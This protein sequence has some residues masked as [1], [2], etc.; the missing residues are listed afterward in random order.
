MAFDVAS[1][2]RLLE[3]KLAALSEKTALP[4]AMLELVAQTARL[5]L[6]A[7]ATDDVVVDPDSLED[8]ERVLRGAPMMP[9]EAFPVDFVLARELFEKLGEVVRHSEPHLAQALGIIDKARASDTLEL[10]QAF[11]RYVAGDDVF[12]TTFGRQTPQAP[13]LLNFLIQAALAPRLAAV[14][15]AVHAHFPADRT[16]NLGQCPVCASPPLIARLVG[17]EGA[18]YLTCSFCLLEYRAKRL[19]CPYCGE[20]DHTKLEVFTSPDEPGYSVHVCLTCKHYIKT[21]DFRELDRPSLPVLDDLE[22]LTLDM[23]AKGQGYSR[24]VLSAWGF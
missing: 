23:A 16:W 3:K 12:F 1:A 13:R 2:S 21:A 8:I 22:S 17:K 5:Q 24:P 18:R 9:R 6:E 19:L 20:E 14:G 10:S 4:A 11:S 15:E 7:R